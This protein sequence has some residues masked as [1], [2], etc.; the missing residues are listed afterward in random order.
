M[1]RE[2]YIKR[3]MKIL[4]EKMVKKLLIFALLIL[5]T[6][7]LFAFMV[8]PSTAKKVK[9]T[10]VVITA[11]SVPDVG[12]MTLAWNYTYQLSVSGE[13]IP[14]DVAVDSNNN[15]IVVGTERTSTIGCKWKVMKLDSA[16]TFLYEWNGDFSIRLDTPVAVD[17]DSTGNIIVVGTEWVPND[18][19]DIRND[20]QWRVMKFDPTLTTILWQ[21]TQKFS[22]LDDQPVDVV[23]DKSDNSII[24]VGYDKARGNINAQW[25]VI[26]Y[27][28]AGGVV[29]N[30]PYELS[31]RHD[32]ASAVTMHSGDIVVVGSVYDPQTGYYDWALKKLSSTDGS[33]N[34][35]CNLTIPLSAR[36]DAPH[37]VAVDL[38]NRIIVVGYESQQEVTQ[39]PYDF[40]W[41]MIKFNS[42][43][44]EGVGSWRW[45]DD[46]SLRSDRPYGVAVDSRNNIIVV[47]FD[48]ADGI[49]YMR[50]RVM[51]FDPLGGEL[52]EGFVDPTIGYS[53]ERPHEV[54]ILEGDNITVVGSDDYPVGWDEDKQWRVAKF[55]TVEICNNDKDDDYDGLVD[56]LDPECPST[57]PPEQ[58]GVDCPEC[59]HPECNVYA[60]WDWTCQNDPVGT[61]CGIERVCAGELCNGGL[62][63][64]ECDI[65]GNPYIRKLNPLDGQD[66]CDGAGVC[67]AYSCAPIMQNCTDDDPGDGVN[68][69]S[70][71]APCDEETDCSQSTWECDTV[72]R[73]YGT[74]DSFGTCDPA[75]SCVDDAF[76]WGDACDFGCTDT[77]YCGN[78]ASYPD[79]ACNCGETSSPGDYPL[80]CGEC[81]VDADCTGKDVNP[82]TDDLCN[83]TINQ[84]YFPSLANG[85]V[86]GGA[87]PALCCLGICDNDGMS[88]TGYHDECRIEECKAPG[89]WG[90][91]PYNQSVGCDGWTENCVNGNICN[92]TR[93]RNT[94]D[95]G[96]CTG[97]EVEEDIA[98]AACQFEDCGVCCSCGSND[99]RAYNS[100][101]SIDCP[102][103]ACDADSCTQISDTNPYTWDW[104]YDVPNSCQALDTCTANTCSYDYHNCSDPSAADYNPVIE[105]EVR[106]CPSDPEDRVCDEPSDCSW[107]GCDPEEEGDCVCLDASCKCERCN[108]CYSGIGSD[109]VGSTCML[110]GGTNTFNPP[111][112][113]SEYIWLWPQCAQQEEGSAKAKMRIYDENGG[114]YEL[115]IFNNQLPKECPNETAARSNCAAEGVELIL[116]Q[117]EELD[118]Y[119]VLAHRIS[120][121][122]G[123]RIE[124]QCVLAGY[125]PNSCDDTDIT[126]IYPDGRNYYLRGT[127]S[128]IYAG[129]EYGGP[130]YTDACQDYR[131][132]N[133]WFCNNTT[134]NLETHA[135]SIGTYY[136]SNGECVGCISSGGHC[137]DHLQCCSGT[138]C[139]RTT[140]TCTGSSGGGGCPTLFVYDGK[141]YVKERKSRIHS[142]G[143][144]VDKIMLNTKPVAED[145]IYSLLLKETTLPEHSYIDSVKLFVDGKEA[146][147]ISAVHS[148]YGDV[149]SIL[150]ASDDI[151]TDTKVFDKIELKFLAPETEGEFLFEIEGYNR[152]WAGPPYHMIKLDINDIAQLIM[153]ILGLGNWF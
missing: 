151:R 26:K 153:G 46:W 98:G 43:C 89:D 129:F 53:S 102:D 135:C 134:R 32:R 31:S 124:V 6:Y 45:A 136:C 34:P 110:W 84:C 121:P 74:R 126:P 116:D 58:G 76:T 97:L 66:T 77:D 119:S 33:I 23:V 19:P 96:Y 106:T 60:V 90:Y 112:S 111:P 35:S 38:D 3:E 149:T 4:K 56:C 125:Q 64:C 9:T 123:F 140:G 107:T 103:T 94:C 17:V 24:V 117:V 54:A 99:D 52:W 12:S 115:C 8:G 150:K 16:G 63:K 143:D 109:F 144:V 67:V 137:S 65:Y 25:R 59:K 71:G 108:F 70:C 147:L 120:G 133:E 42:D 5:F 114:E 68:A 50:W 101:Q 1:V 118:N 14:N 82:C 138:Y 131:Y 61:E 152:M 10:P 87:E 36:T 20:Y 21:D 127:V 142:E 113:A 22:I 69:F 15:I 100:T 95:T 88:G 132:L 29:W 78:C 85:T 57:L 122:D 146:E 7:F 79:G 104:T 72:N 75:C 105:G 27:N 55:K 62:N 83:T 13:D 141:D 11:P 28:S 47:G 51:K 49:D 86:C 80:D 2:K 91:S 148:K 128:G 37:D 130:D 48:Q 40:R 73:K 139:S 18:N 44:T 39:E 145:G 30:E 92:S 93:S 81:Y 41:R